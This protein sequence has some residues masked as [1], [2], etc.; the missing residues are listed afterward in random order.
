[1]KFKQCKRILNGYFA[2]FTIFSISP[3]A[4]AVAVRL[5]AEHSGRRLPVAQQSQGRRG[6]AQAASTNATSL[7][8]GFFRSLRQPL[9]VAITPF[10]HRKY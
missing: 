8:H 9:Y 7:A 1:M 10:F 5:V 4:I 3:L 2:A 6:Q